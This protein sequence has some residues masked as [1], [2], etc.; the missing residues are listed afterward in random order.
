MLFIDKDV[1]SS[2][3]SLNSSSLGEFEYVCCKLHL[4]ESNSIGIL[5]IYRPPNISSTGDSAVLNLITEFLNLNI[6]YKVL[7]GDFNMSFVNWKNFSGPQK[8]LSFLD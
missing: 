3:V 5:C 6:P 7:V 2:E 1:R 4:T 8:Y